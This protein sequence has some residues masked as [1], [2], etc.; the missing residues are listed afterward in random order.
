M[1]GKKPKSPEPEINNRK[2]RHDYAITD[3]LECGIILYG[4]EVK[5]IRAGRMSLGEG[6]VRATEVPLSLELHGVRIDEYAPAG[7]S[8]QHRPT[9]TRTLLAHKREIRKLARASQQ[10]GVT[11]VPLKAYFKNGRVK[12]LIGLGTGK[13]SYDKRQDIK[14]RDAQRE[15]QRAMS[16][17]M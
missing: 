6:Y 10:K 2:A 15:V 13:R 16:K 11:I 12:I 8:S 5:S 7:A 17:R 4:T 1:A 3:T 14:K 9:Q